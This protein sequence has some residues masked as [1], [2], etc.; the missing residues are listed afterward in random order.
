VQDRRVRRLTALLVATMLAG[1]TS[2]SAAGAAAWLPPVPGEPTR[3]FHLGPNPFLRGQHRGVDF[4]ARGERVRAACAGRVVFAGKVAGERT[5]SVRCGRWRVSYAP[6]A[7]VAVR[8]GEAIGAGTRLGLA[9]RGELHFGVRREGRRF[10][11]VDPL[12]F[13]D[14]PRA[15]PPVLGPRGGRPRRGARPR[16]DRPIRAP[17]PARARLA[18]AARP[19]SALAPWPVWLGLALG[20]IGL[21]GAGRLR[22]PFR[23]PGG[24]PCRAS[25]TSNSSPT[26][27]S[28]P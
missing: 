7:R 2:A 28:S 12:R 3:L 8:G 4:A 26:T 27:P 13:L 6:L 14:A 9:S 5:V 11:Y 19:H 15:P 18:R 21:I 1:S 23:R 25:S 24:A 20:L 10:G 17:H 22:L 16:I